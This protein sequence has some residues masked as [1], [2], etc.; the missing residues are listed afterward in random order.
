[1]KWNLV[2]S[3]FV[4]SMLSVNAFAL[5]THAA[6]VISHK[7][8]M[9]GN[10]TG[11]FKDATLDPKIKN[12]LTLHRSAIKSKQGIFGNMQEDWNKNLVEM[13]SYLFEGLEGD[14]GHR[15]SVGYTPVY[16]DNTT[17][18]EHLYKI[19]S[20]LCVMDDVILSPSSAADGLGCY[21]AESIIKVAPHQSS[22]FVPQ[23]SV[24]YIAEPGH[25][26]RSDISSFVSLDNDNVTTF[27]TSEYMLV[28]ADQKVANK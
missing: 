8:S 9:T 22:E 14:S 15:S 21:H 2:L 27:E 17:N 11:S 18:V 7:E 26:Y 4:V 19:D 13:D 6:Q 20:W 28:S 10:I 24:R 23:L 12:M 1:M 25:T 5:D 16:M 3:S